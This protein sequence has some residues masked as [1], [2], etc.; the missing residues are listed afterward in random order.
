[1][2]KND[3]CEAIVNDDIYIAPVYTQNAPDGITL[4]LGKQYKRKVDFVIEN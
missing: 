2:N 3:D 1:M 4:D